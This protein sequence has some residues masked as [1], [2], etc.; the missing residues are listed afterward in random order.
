MPIRLALG[1][2]EGFDET[3]STFAR[4]LGLSSVQFHTPSDLKGD[5]RVLD[6]DELVR[7][8]ERCE[9][10]GLVVEGI[11]NVP[12]AHW[13]SVLRGSPGRDEQLENYAR[14]SATWRPPG[15]SS[16]VTI[17][18]RRT[19]GGPTCTRAGA[20]GPWSP[21]ST[22][23]SVGDGNALTGYKLTPGERST[24]PIGSERMWDN[25][26]VFLDAVLPVAEEVGVRLA[27]HPDDPPTDIPLGGV[28]R[29]LSSP[30][31]LERAGESRRGSPAWGLD[32]CLGTVSEMG[33]TATCQ[34]RHRH[35]RAAGR[36]VYVHFRDVQ[37]VVPRFQECFLGE[38]N[39][40]PAAVL[41]RLAAV[42][43]DGFLID[44]HVPAMIG[45]EDTW[46]N[47][48]SA[49]L[50]QPRSGARH[51][52]PAGPAPRPRR[53]DGER[54]SPARAGQDDGWEDRMYG[55]VEAGG[56]K[57][58]CAHAR[59]LRLPAALGAAAPVDLA[60]WTEAALLA[61]AGIDCVVYG[62]GDIAQAHAP[63]E[64]VPIAELER[65]RDTFAARAGSGRGALTMEPADVVLRFLEIGRL[66]P[67]VRLLPR[68][69]FAPASPS[70]SPPSPSTPTSRATPAK[71]S[72][73]I[74]A[75]SPR[76]ASI[77]VVVL[78]VFESTEA[79]E[80]ATRLVRRLDKAGVRA[81]RHR[82]R[83]ARSAAARRRGRARA[84]HPH[85]RLSRRC[86]G[87]LRGARRA[88]RA[89]CARASSSSCIARAACGRAASSCRSCNLTTDAAA[90]AHAKELS[91]KERALVDE[92]RKL[93]RA[94]AARAVGRH[95]LAAQPVP[96]AVHDQGRRHA[97][98]SRRAHRAPRASPSSIASGCARS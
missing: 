86:R 29:I 67:R 5:A 90:L 98:A 71:R 22:P 14:R 79:M 77:P 64:F 54:V 24:E 31:A 28:A 63:D 60:F 20:A 91:R 50:L 10:D 39:Y 41:R 59:A 69:S 62:P 73:S 18:C 66:A 95:H 4:Q 34:P 35:V 48:T 53:R 25:Y 94:H 88:H 38:G 57:F 75:S 81:V 8:R 32:L 58:V 3:V 43:F 11:E 68:R 97:A 45:D 21:H 30:Q 6:V 16:S 70:A 82:L 76:S 83:R 55:G 96:R 65:A 23:R 9:A 92:S 51:R 93:R 33:G 46:A 61:A 40:D 47:T 27:L 89:R 56:T 7:L 42:G 52:V 37:G 26:R 36:I 78:G 19:C 74:C 44:D 85:R 84:D 49:R 2:L 72:R 1:H 12:Y 80:Q 15:S 17:S 87:A 13:D